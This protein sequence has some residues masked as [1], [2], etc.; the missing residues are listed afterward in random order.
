MQEWSQRYNTTMGAPP[1]EG[2][3]TDNQLA[4]L[5]K[6]TMILKQASYTDFSVWTL[7]R[8]Q[9]FRTLVPLGDGSFLTKELPGPQNLQQWLASWRVFKVA[10]I[11]LGIVSLAALQQYE[12]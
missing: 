11:S 8:S 5:Y 4:P 9:K 6:R 7:I 3:A 2:E 12:N 1:E 10:A